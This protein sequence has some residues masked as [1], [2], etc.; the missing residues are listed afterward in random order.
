MELRPYQQ[1][2]VDRAL[3]WM[4]SSVDPAIID[5]A[6]AAGKSFMIAAIAKKLNEI[7]G[8]RVLCLAPNAKLIKQNH[9]KFLM[10]GEKASIFSAS[11]GQKST[12]HTVVFATPGTVK[13]AISRFTKT[14]QDGYCAVVVD[15]CHG[16]TPTVI[17]IIETMKTANP[18]LRVMGL[19]GTP[20]RL[21]SGYI[22]RAWPDNERGL[23]KVNDDGAA[24]DPFFTKCVYRVP[25]RLMLDQ[26]FITPM[27]VGQIGS[28]NSYDTSSVVLLA[29]GTPNHATI[30][31]AF[32][33]HGRKTAMIVAD[34]IEK[35]RERKGGI[36]YFAATV[37]HAHEILAS[38]P[39]ESSALVT[40]DDCI[41]KGKEYHSDIPI[42]KAYRDREIRHLISV[43]MLTTGFDVS[44]T[45]TIATM[46]YSESA[47]LITQIL[48]RAWRLDD[49]K[50]TCLWLDY[51][52]NCDRHFPDG[53][54]YNPEIKAKK[55]SGGGEPIE[56]ECPA[57]NHVNEFGLNPDYADY[58]I[59]R[60][61]YCMDV[62]GEP[63]LTEFGQLS[64]HYGRRCFGMLQTG[65]SG[66]YERCNYRWVGKECPHCT[67]IND[68]AARFCYVCKGEIVDPNE[69]LSA[70]FKALKRDPTKPQTDIVTHLAISEGFSQKGNPTLRADWTT[71]HR[72]FSTWFQPNAT[73]R[74]AQVDHE[75]FIAA[76][77]DGWPATVSYVKEANGFYRCLSYNMPADEAPAPKAPLII[78]QDKTRHAA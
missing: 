55:A 23:S 7:S 33:G 40:G 62:F 65:A 46:R 44:H 78:E 69:K 9:E 37:R 41:W 56:A 8:K 68:I 47:Q 12:R 45:E 75:R 57:C 15:E 14:G 50:E 76:T 66:T 60:H 26:G 5:A 36:M 28:D 77:K 2:A 74:K 22:F 54:I 19:T 29:N 30:E 43:G 42:I 35:A 11:A 67:E 58:K 51:A 21:G 4:R 25:A 13:N 52:G 64:A 18:M 59:N 72:S 31:Q 38:L 49:D 63:I 32:E 34:I 61:G 70:D 3:K 16:I 53:D 48:G 10:T 6:P 17:S 39:V 1:E 24:R 73:F 27:E 20:Y 71:P